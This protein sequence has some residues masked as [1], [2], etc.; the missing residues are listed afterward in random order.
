MMMKKCPTCQSIVDD[1]TEC[2]I[3][4]TT[5]TYEP[6]IDSDKEKLKPNH[7][8]YFFLAKKLSFSMVCLILVA[9]LEGNSGTF[10]KLSAAGIALSVL[11][12]LF[13]IFEER[14]IL[15][16][17]RMYSAEYAAFRI[18]STKFVCGIIAVILAFLVFLQ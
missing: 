15:K 18:K 3:C 6:F 13:A 4:G 16:N 14:L 7:Y 11:S 1:D 10:N 12:F 8:L 2:K 9:V 5:L 17:R